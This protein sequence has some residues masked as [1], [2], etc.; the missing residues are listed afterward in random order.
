[1]PSLPN[2][3]SCIRT[4]LKHPK[5]KGAYRGSAKN[6]VFRLKGQDPDPSTDDNEV[7][8]LSVSFRV[9]KKLTPIAK[10]GGQDI[11]LK[12]RFNL[13]CARTTIREANRIWSQAGIQFVLKHY[14]EYHVPESKLKKPVTDYGIGTDDIMA[15]VNLWNNRDVDNKAHLQVSVTPYLDNG[16]TLGL[17]YTGSSGNRYS[18]VMCE[19]VA[20]TSEGVIPQSLPEMCNTLAHEIGHALDFSHARPKY[21]LMAAVALGMDDKHQ[22]EELTPKQV[23]KAR[24]VVR[25]ILAGTHRSQP[26]QAEEAVKGTNIKYI[27]CQHCRRR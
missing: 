1:M 11:E 16:G 13:T 27:K 17:N 12:S 23:T 25:E 20:L 24:R 10:I 14:E 5:P 8:T 18:I 26:L 4:S 9:V 21:N 22:Q 15:I 2:K 6:P 19:Y 3:C 7:L